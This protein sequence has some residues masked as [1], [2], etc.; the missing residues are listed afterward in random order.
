[1]PAGGGGFPFD[2]DGE[3]RLH[4]WDVRLL[5]VATAHANARD[6]VRRS[7]CHSYRGYL[8]WLE[9]AWPTAVR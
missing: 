9:G 6:R 2:S 7:G 3:H 4:D 8:A 1:M 5:G